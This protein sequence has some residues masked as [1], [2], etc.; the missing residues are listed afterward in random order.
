M[1]K[2]IPASRAETAA[3]KVATGALLRLSEVAALLDVAPATVHSLELPSIRIGKSLRF[4]PIDVRRLIETC[5]EPV[6]Y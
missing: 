1:N 6:I 5:R 4:D 3:R 2:D